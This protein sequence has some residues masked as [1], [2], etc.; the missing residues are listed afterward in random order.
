MSISWEQLG[1]DRAIVLKEGNPQLGDENLPKPAPAINESK[2]LDE[3]FTEQLSVVF[4]HINATAFA[5]NQH[6]AIINQH[7]R[8]LATIST[9]IP[10]IEAWSGT[11]TSVLAPIHTNI[12]TLH[13]KLSS[14]ELAQIAETESR[15]KAIEPLHLH[16]K[17][18]ELR[19]QAIEEKIGTLGARIDEVE[20]A[21]LGEVEDTKRRAISR[22][23]EVQ[24]RIGSLEK[25]TLW[26]IKDFDEVLKLKP[27][28]ETINNVIRTELRMIRKQEKDWRD[29]EKMR[30][31][32]DKPKEEE[33]GSQSRPESGELVE[34][35]KKKLEV[36]KESAGLP[37]K[38]QFNFLFSK[39]SELEN[40]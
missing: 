39:I 26:K 11:L 34:A 37:S 33:H 7:I 23:G 13:S 6:S 15:N 9:I 36:A 22:I 14:L 10:Q 24:D 21:C 4:K 32:P 29:Y 17:F 5:L 20:S 35:E 27:N 1:L 25:N 28:L 2:L 40:R 38:Q 8:S 18:V 30:D 19:L 12:S 16:D 31:S 3:S